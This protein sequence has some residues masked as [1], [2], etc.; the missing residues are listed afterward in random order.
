MMTPLPHVRQAYSLLVQEEMQ[1]QVTSER[2]KKFSIASIVQKKTTY[3]KFAKEKSCEYCN[4]SG[5]TIDECRILKFHGKFCDRRGHTEDRCLQKN[6]SR[7]AVQVNQRNNRG[8]RSFANMTDVSQLNIEE[9]SSNSIP[10]FS[11]EQL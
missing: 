4:K 2:T 7:R 6:N 5:H 11:S 9:Q 1:H 3:S 10:I 8:Y